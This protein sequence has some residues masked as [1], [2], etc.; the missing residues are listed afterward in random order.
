MDAGARLCLCATGRK[1]KSSWHDM[2]NFLSG[3]FYSEISVQM[4]ARMLGDNF[5]WSTPSTAWGNIIEAVKFTF[6]ITITISVALL[7]PNLKI[8]A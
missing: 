1:A 6:T 5:D 7:K 4:R 2:C 8:R 3:G